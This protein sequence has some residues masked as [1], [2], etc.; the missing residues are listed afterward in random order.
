MKGVDE[1]A[2]TQTRC[3]AVTKGKGLIWRQLKRSNDRY[4]KEEMKAAEVDPEVS[5]E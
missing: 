5:P 4:T 1:E 2:C 3:E